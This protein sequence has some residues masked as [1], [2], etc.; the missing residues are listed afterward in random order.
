MLALFGSLIGLIIALFGYIAWDRRTAM[1]P[2]LQRIEAV[3][4]DLR[5]LPERRT[6]NSAV[7][8]LLNVLKNLARED[9]KVAAALSKYVKSTA[10]PNAL[11]PQ[12]KEA[13]GM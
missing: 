3:E 12:W 4:Q 5:E 11:P 9:S 8:Q 2:L 10:K 7:T 13:E 6:E 1:R